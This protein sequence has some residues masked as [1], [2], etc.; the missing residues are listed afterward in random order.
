MSRGFRERTMALIRPILAGLLLLVPGAA[1]AETFRVMPKGG[2]TIAEAIAAAAPGDTVRLGPGV[3][4]GPVLIDRP[5][6][7]LTGDGGAIVDG[8]GK[9]NVIKVTAPDVTVRGLTIR[10]SGRSLQK[11]DSGVF[12][13]P[14][15]DRAQIVGNHV[16]DDLIG[17]YLS[18]P[19]E[20]EVRSNRIDGVRDMR[21]NERGNGVQL[22]N[23]PGSVV[24]GN[25]VR[26]GRD[27]IFV[28]TSRN[29]VFRGNEF[30]DVRFAIHYM[31]TND[32]EVSG[33]VSEGNHVGYALM[34][35]KGLRVSG[36]LSRGDRDHG[37]MLNYANDSSITGNRVIDG[38]AKCVFIY[39]SNTNVFQGN[40]FK[41]CAIGVHFTAGSERNE[42]AGNAFIGNRTQVKYVGTRYLDW[43]VGGRGNYWSDN[44]AFDLNGDGIAD[45]TYRPNDLIDQVVWAHPMAKMLLNAPG[46]QV[47]RW[48]QS[49]FP[50]LH[51]GGVSDSA[52]LMAPPAGSGTEG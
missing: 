34:Y 20:A 24:E 12:V 31:Y 7:T 33:N 32:S 39:N 14:E 25:S 10:N 47:V 3:H 1:G 29:N 18:G 21:L 44:P 42:I 37:I 13:T 9:G 27:G 35:S 4:A 45:S 50:A 26:W 48:A 49:R 15:G 22:W 11:Q 43:S 28:T 40:L 46:I 16:V 6:I 5:G 23:T 41:G 38:E 36:N 30:H 17:V 19:E 8:G 2:P 51:P 52:P